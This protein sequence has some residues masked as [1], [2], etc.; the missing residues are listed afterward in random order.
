MIVH[1]NHVK[2]HIANYLIYIILQK[3]YST[4][5]IHDVHALH[6]TVTTVSAIIVQ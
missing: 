3:F 2:F 5:T 1:H 6:C 4:V